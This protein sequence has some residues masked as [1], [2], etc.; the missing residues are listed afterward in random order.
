MRMRTTRKIFLNRPYFYLKG[1]F[2]HRCLVITLQSEHYLKVEIL[3]LV[4]LSKV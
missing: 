1:N 2:T 4:D 3:G